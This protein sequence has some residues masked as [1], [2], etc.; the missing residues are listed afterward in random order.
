MRAGVTLLLLFAASAARAGDTPAAAGD[1]PA[2]SGD[3]IAAAKKDFASIK[4][5]TTPVESGPVLPTFEMKDL[6]PSPGAAR[7]AAP[8]LTP[9]DGQSPLDPSGKKAAGGTGNWLVDAME[10]KPDGARSARGRDDLLRGDQDPARD[11]D[12]LGTQDD[13]DAESSADARERASSRDV[14]DSV[15]NPLDAFMG[16]WISTRDH[17]LL[18]P[19]TKGDTLIGGDLEKARADTLPGIDFGPSGAVAE[20]AL[21]APDAGWASSNAEANPYLAA[22]DAE[23][24]AAV[25]AFSSPELPAFSSPDSIDAPRGAISS[26]ADPAQADTGRSLIPD[27]AQPSDD[28]KYFKQMKRF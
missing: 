27:F 16:G 7:A 12:R 11:G 23:P 26:G 25:K 13:R 15:Y 20:A 14:A 8:A 18:L 21:S 5:T 4:L 17:E 19:G 22:L 9:A 2:P 10:K 6:G 24:A 1:A 28:D 3:S